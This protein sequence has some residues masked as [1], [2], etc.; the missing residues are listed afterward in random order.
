MKVINI[1]KRTIE[2]PKE[3]MSQLFKTLTTSDDLVW[4]YENWL[5]IRFKDGLNVGNKQGY[6]RIRYT[7]IEHKAGETIT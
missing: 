6:G 5:A 2:Q 7:I 3:K 4:P 1:Y